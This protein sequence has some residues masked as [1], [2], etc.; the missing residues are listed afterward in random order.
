M[1][2]GESYSFNTYWSLPDP[3]NRFIG[4]SISSTNKSSSLASPSGFEFDLYT[5]GISCC[6]CCMIFV[7]IPIIMSS[8]IVRYPKIHISYDMQSTKAFLLCA[9]RKGLVDLLQDGAQLSVRDDHFHPFD[10]IFSVCVQPLFCEWNRSRPADSFRGAHSALPLDVA[11]RR[12]PAIGK[13]CRNY[14]AGARLPVEYQVASNIMRET[15]SHP[16]PA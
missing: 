8:R 2:I 10:V 9:L 6:T 13:W 15:V 16:R 11:P 14:G 1:E 4:V 12:P 3:G 7:V 5:H